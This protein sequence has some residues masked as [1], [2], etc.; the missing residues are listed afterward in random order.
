MTGGYQASAQ[1][2]FSKGIQNVSAGWV[3]Q[4]LV[5]IRK[6]AAAGATAK[7][8]GLAIGKSG[9]TARNLIYRNNIV[10]NR[11]AIADRHL[12]ASAGAI[13]A[14]EKMGH[15]QWVKEG[16]RLYQSGMSV[17]DVATKLGVTHAAVATYFSRHGVRPVKPICRKRMA[18][19]QK[20]LALII[21][22]HVEEV[23]SEGQVQAAT[24]LDR[25]EIRRLYDEARAA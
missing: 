25:P 11:R 23:L 3:D 13:G 21:R 6:M 22:L 24:G 8:I 15:A 2:V 18:S 10:W 17:R 1:R 9:A 5:T 14:H 20:M 4:E 19:R 7:E 16:I 12:I